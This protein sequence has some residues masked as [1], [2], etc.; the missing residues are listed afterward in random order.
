MI[1]VA[2]FKSW[3][4]V[5]LHPWTP[6]F[7][8]ELN[9]KS[10]IHTWVGVAVGAFLGL[11]LSW[12]T[13]LL[14]GQPPQAFMGI[15]S[16]WVAAGVQPPFGS[17]AVIA[18]LGVILGFFNFQIVLFIFARL[19]GGKGS[20][21]AQAYAQSLFYG[22]LAIVQQVL[23]VI[24]GV[25][26]LLFMLLAA[27]SLV[28][29]TTSLKAAHGYST[30]RAVTTWL[31]PI[32]LNILVVF[33]IVMML[34][35]C[36]GAPT[37]SPTWVAAEPPAYWPTP[38]WRTSTP[39]AQGIDSAPIL[40]LL[41]E[42]QQKELNVHSVLVLRHGYL[43]TEV[44]FPPYTQ[45]IKHPLHSI[46]KSVTSAMTGI[47]IQEG[48]IESVQQ[49]VLDFFPEIAKE[50]KDD[51]LRDLTI[52]HL[53]TMSAGFN[54]HT[55]PNFNDPASS[56]DAVEY[57]L[58]HSNVLRK[59]GETFFYDSGLPH[60]VSAILQKTSGLTLEAYTQKNL[61][62]P[63][64]ITDFSWQ[65]DPQGITTGYTGLSLRPRD[66]AKLG[67][68]YLHNG[69]WNGKQIAPAEWVQASTTGHKETK[70]L[71]NAAEDDGYGYYWWIDSF[72]GYSA[73]GHGGQYVFVLPQLDM[74]VV[75]TGSLAD[76][77]FPT[78]HRL[79]K[80]YLLPAAQPP[81]A[82][83]LADNPQ[84]FNQLTAEIVSIQNP[85]KPVAPLP[86]IAK[87]ISGKTFQITGGASAGWP[88]K[89]TLTF[90]GG[91]TY[92]SEMV[93][94]GETLK[95]AGGLNNVFYL[96]RLGPEGETIAPLRGYWQDDHTF[97]EEQNFDLFSE[98]QFFT[99]T[100]T[101]E[102]K[103]VSLKVESSMGYFSPLQAAGEIVE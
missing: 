9:H 67:Y 100:Y 12:L 1:N 83:P 20:F 65:S 26:R 92:T 72:G 98:I 35:G 52:E 99:V 32:L 66:M 42:I 70:G 55:L 75:F 30:W 68:L 38:E 48:R 54:T 74:I 16:I 6:I 23:A 24:P 19:L 41:Q 47:A 36:A 57:I 79:L 93:M 78:P 33:G 27:Y 37:A 96:N 53:L 80:T 97:I 84:L 43:V 21:G 22:P 87:Q 63:L 62:G 90:P 50:T 81:G 51:Y 2:L 10:N 8:D 86:E 34:S 88:E 13:H 59:P 64:G 11:G 3:V 4:K 31:M 14:F 76:P 82:Q 91:D 102:G 69:Q 39:E 17:W 95:V 85:E 58:T 77:D 29:T 89:I 46:T 25:G 103:K 101:F 28:P 18:P 7:R 61:F 71:M 45:D 49:R 60:V 15:A 5:F 40:A 94:P 56:V 73:H 44:Y